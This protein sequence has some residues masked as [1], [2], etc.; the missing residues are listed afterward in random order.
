MGIRTMGTRNALFLRNRRRSRSATASI[1]L[2]LNSNI[3]ILPTSLAAGPRR[4]RSSHHR[5][6]GVGVFLRRRV[7]QPSTRVVEEDVLE[8]RLQERHVLHLVA[9]GPRDFRDR[10]ERDHV[11]PENHAR[12]VGLLPSGVPYVGEPF[13]RREELVAD[14][15][16]ELHREDVLTGDAR[17]ELPKIGRAHV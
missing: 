3:S 16:E 14:F 4:R 12:G 17:L 10:L 15:L 2:G 5:R 13:E 1:R 7:P 6:Y 11:A 8:R 9:V